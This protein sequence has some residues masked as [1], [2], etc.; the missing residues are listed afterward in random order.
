MNKVI[1]GDKKLKNGFIME[2]RADGN[3][4]QK[5]I[6]DGNIAFKVTLLRFKLEWR[7]L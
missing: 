5:K 1:G 2:E 7:L 6:V 3:L 4:I